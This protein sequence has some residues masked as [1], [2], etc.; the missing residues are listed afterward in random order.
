MI[1]R[2]GAALEAWYTAL[3]EPV[4]RRLARVNPNLI[5]AASLV[6]G[7]LAGVAYWMTARDPS[8]FLLGASL[9]ALS[10][11]SDS[12][13]GLVARRSGR[14]SELGDFL[15]HFFDRVVEIAILAGLAFSP[16]ATTGLGLAVGL[17][18]L[19]NSYLGTQIEASF[20]V[21]SYSGLGKAELFVGLVLGSLL[22][23]YIPSLSIRMLERS[24]T[25]VDLFFLVVALLTLQAMHHRLRLAMRLARGFP[26]EK[27]TTVV[28][29][30][31]TGGRILNESADEPG[32]TSRD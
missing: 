19:L 25:L 31:R 8:Y 26:G 6:T 23:A 18:V 4:A 11:V 27:G 20:G 12:L 5:S 9:V 14:S 7:C 16:T 13:D 2:R 15:D 1:S 22:L 24:L 32:I 10:G 29:S 21:R 28:R 30:A 17:V 3:L